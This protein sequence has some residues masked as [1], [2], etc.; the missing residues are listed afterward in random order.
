M[1]KKVAAGAAALA[2]VV[3]AGLGAR[4]LVSDE[5]CVPPRTIL[6]SEQ[7]ASIAVLE[8]YIEE[9]IASSFKHP[10]FLLWASDDFAPVIKPGVISARI[11]LIESSAAPRYY[12]V[13]LVRDSIGGEWKVVEFKPVKA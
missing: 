6:E 10:E 13:K 9:N 4:Q 2:V 5:S 8:A 1:K 7:T 3:G 12:H 11:V